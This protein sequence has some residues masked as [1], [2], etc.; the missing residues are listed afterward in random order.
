MLDTENVKKQV[1]L[2]QDGHVTLLFFWSSQFPT[3]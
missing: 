3:L 2:Q 1:F